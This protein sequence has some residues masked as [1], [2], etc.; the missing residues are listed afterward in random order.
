MTGPGS[1][2][3]PLLEVTDIHKTYRDGEAFAEVLK[4]ISFRVESGEFVAIPG[5][6]KAPEKALS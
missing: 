1:P 5:G 2:Q 3:M 6:V 4:G